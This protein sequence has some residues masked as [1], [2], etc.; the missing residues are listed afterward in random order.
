MGHLM[1]ESDG[2]RIGV[3]VSVDGDKWLAA[4]HHTKV[5]KLGGSWFCDSDF[6][7]VSGQP[8]I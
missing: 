1:R 2:E 8:F 5:S 7:W 4:R 6:T 3:Q